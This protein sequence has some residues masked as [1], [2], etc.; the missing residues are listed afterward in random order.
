MEMNCATRKSLEVVSD[1]NLDNLEDGAIWQKET[2]N[3]KQRILQKK[4][5]KQKQN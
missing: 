2:R 3:G 4:K 1:K 5:Q